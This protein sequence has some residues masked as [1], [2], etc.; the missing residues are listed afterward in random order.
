MGWD[1]MMAPARQ[2]IHPTPD[3]AGV[4]VH[5]DDLED[6]SL[7][8]A[9]PSRGGSLFASEGMAGDGHSKYSYSVSLRLEP[10]VCTVIRLLRGHHE[11][12]NYRAA[13]STKCE[14]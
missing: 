10:K 3:E 4:K 14:M 11:P 1:L 6:I 2:V 8:E 12:Y 9:L 5:R 7:A 13:L